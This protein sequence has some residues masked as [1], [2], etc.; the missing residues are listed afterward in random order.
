MKMEAAK[1]SEMLVSYYPSV[2]KH[3]Y[4]NSDNLNLNKTA[5]VNKETSKYQKTTLQFMKSK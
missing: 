2:M 5:S 4:H 3:G 1:Y